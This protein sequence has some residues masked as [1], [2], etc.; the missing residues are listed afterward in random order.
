MRNGPLTVLQTTH[1]GHGAGSTQ[2]IFSLSLYLA[3][4]GHRILVACRP[5][6]LLSRWVERAA[7]SGLTPVPLDFS[8]LGSLARDLERT[9]ATRRVDVVNSH[10]SRDRRALTWLRWCGRL[11]QALVV[12]RRTMPLTSPPEVLAVGL[13]ADRTIAVSE[14][15]AR[16]LR[17][18]GHPPG[19]VRVV[20]NGID[21]ARVDATP[22][23]AELA[24]AREALG[25]LGQRPLVVVVS[26]RKDQHVLLAHL[27][28]VTMPVAVALVGIDPDPQLRAL[29][30][31]LPP[32]HRVVYVPFTERPLAFYH[33]AVAAA[34]PTRIEGFSQALL[35][36]MALGVPVIA[37][38]SGGNPELVADGRTGLLVPTRRPSMWADAL[39]RLLRDPVLR[40]TLGEAGRQLVRERFTLEQVSERTEAVYRDALAR[41]RL[42]REEAR[43]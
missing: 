2:S 34:L 18:R 36:A 37:S 19:R 41:R 4:R 17:R 15:V 32:R 25:D 23:G 30:A 31:R 38:A 1:A 6:S 13:T 8:R 9:I 7:G 27:P 10:D 43:R 21:V 42:L 26:R 28:Q 29:E 3:R 5:D 20:H 14:A 11:P 16:A 39:D 35:E 33:L 24:A 40:R 22:T 12:T